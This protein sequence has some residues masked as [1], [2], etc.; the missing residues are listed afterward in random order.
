VQPQHLILS[1]LNSATA[2]VGGGS[3]DRMK[4]VHDRMD[5]YLLGKA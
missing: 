2:E 4:D 1:L 3:R 5:K